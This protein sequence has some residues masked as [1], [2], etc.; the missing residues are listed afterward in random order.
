MKSKFALISF[1][2]VEYVQGEN[3]VQLMPYG[4]QTNNITL[5]KSGDN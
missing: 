5:N 1:L 4:M 3:G 2:S